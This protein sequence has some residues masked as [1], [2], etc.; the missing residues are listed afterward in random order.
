LSN[1]E[2]LLWFLLFLFN[3]FSTLNEL[4]DESPEKA[5]HFVHHM[6]DLYRFVLKNEQTDTVTLAEEVEFSMN[7]YAMLKERFGEHL[8]CHFE[9]SD[10]V[11]L[12]RVPPMAI[13]MLIENAVKHNYFDEQQPLHIFIRSA[14]S[15][16]TVNNQMHKR[17]AVEGHGMGLYN[18]NQRYHFLSNN[19]VIVRQTDDIFEVQIPLIA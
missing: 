14:E 11:G 3:S 5:K 2:K 19:E 18:L 16:V 17:T 1:R 13:Q 7:Y 9:I 6:S 4:I 8:H 10:Q 15:H 12:K